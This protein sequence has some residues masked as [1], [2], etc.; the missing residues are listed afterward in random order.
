MGGRLN[1]W[2]M[3]EDQEGAVL[4][5]EENDEDLFMSGVQAMVSSWPMELTISSGALA[6]RSCSSLP[7]VKKVQSA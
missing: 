2:G 5:E 3:K 6:I 4:A 7:I 1:G